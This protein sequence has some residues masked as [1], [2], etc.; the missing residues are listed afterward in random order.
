MEALCPPRSTGGRTDIGS[1]ATEYRALLDLP[2]GD[3]IAYDT[4]LISAGRVR[5]LVVTSASLGPV[6]QG[7]KALAA[8]EAEIQA[9]EVAVAQGI[10]RRVPS[11]HRAPIA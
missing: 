7:Q 5:L 1:F 10:A 11:H 2:N 8:A 9:V 6:D 3:R 4:I